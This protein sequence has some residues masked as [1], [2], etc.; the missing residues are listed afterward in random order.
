M[1]CIILAGGKGSRI[2]KDYPDIP[3]AMV[4]ILGKP[5]LEYEIEMLRSYGIN[6][7]MIITGH[8]HSAIENY[9]KDGSEYGVKITY[10]R[11][12]FPLGTAGALFNVEIKEDFL[13]CAG[14]LLF[15]FSLNKMIEFHK[16]NNALATVFS[17]PSSHPF[18]STLIKSDEDG[19]IID[20]FRINKSIDSF[21]NNCSAGIYMISPKLL[22]LRRNKLQGKKCDIDE[23]ILQESVDTDRIFS[24]KSTEFV[25]DIGTP[26]RKCKA[27]KHL[28][29]FGLMPKHV[30]NGNKAIFLD[31]DGTLNT[32]K[33]YITDKMQIELTDKAAQ[34]INIFHS[35]GYLVIL[36]TNQPVVARGDCSIEVLK[37]INGRVEYLLGKDNSYLDDIFFCPHHP[38]KGFA[39]ENKE[40]KIDCS[41]RKPKPGMILKATEKYDINLSESYMVGDTISDVN[42]AKNAGCTPVL[43]GSNTESTEDV[44]NVKSL[45]DFAAWLLNKNGQEIS[46][47]LI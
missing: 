17:H 36:V 37:E 27:E 42:C 15:N 16:S 7:I 4:P 33:G 45:Y 11:E 28:L 30:Q 2:S 25:C 41:C 14:D 40:F 34:A 46:E 13:L 6:E 19:K 31:R 29:I 26:E 10:Y 32:Y 9:F 23:D 43:I 8:L 47:D 44:L 35:L 1:I 22:E 24:Y 3:K 38:H 21:N 5:V 12:S 20:F 39:N 18:D